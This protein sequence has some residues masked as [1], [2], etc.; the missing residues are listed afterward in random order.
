VKLKRHGNR[1]GERRRERERGKEEERGKENSRKR[2][3][4]RM[5]VWQK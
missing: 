2:V 4:V 1:E 5:N 3:L